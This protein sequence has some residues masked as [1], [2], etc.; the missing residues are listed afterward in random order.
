MLHRNRKLSTLMFYVA[1]D[2]VLSYKQV[3]TRD[4]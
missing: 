4:K 1:E 3:S 2:L